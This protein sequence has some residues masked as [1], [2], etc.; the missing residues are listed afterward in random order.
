MTHWRTTLPIHL[1][2]GY[3]KGISPTVGGKT[4]VL[5]EA[6][7]RVLFASATNYVTQAAD[8]GITVDQRKDLLKQAAEAT[9]HGN[10]IERLRLEFRQMQETLREI[11]NSRVIGGNDYRKELDRIKLLARRHI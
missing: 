2:T 3:G 7:S 6:T 9:E 5:A 1:D 8:P 11:A 4:P 10:R